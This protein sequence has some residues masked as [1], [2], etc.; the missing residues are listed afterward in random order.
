M[1]TSAW[2]GV[3]TA[4]PRSGP[5]CVRVAASSADLTRCGCTW[6]SSTS[7]LPL[8]H[9]RQLR[10]VLL[11]PDV[12]AVSPAL[13]PGDAHQAWPDEDP[14]QASVPDHLP[15][16]TQGSGVSPRRKRSAIARRHRWM[17]RPPLPGS[18]PYAARLALERGPAHEGEK[19]MQFDWVDPGSTQPAQIDGPPGQSV[20]T[21]CPCTGEWPPSAAKA[22][23]HWHPARPAPGRRWQDPLPRGRRGRHPWSDQSELSPQ[24][25]HQGRPAARFDE[26]GPQPG[27]SPLPLLVPAPEAK[28]Q[29]RLSPAPASNSERRAALAR[30]SGCALLHPH[31][32]TSHEGRRR[33]LPDG[34]RPQPIPMAP[35]HARGVML[36]SL[37][38]CEGMTSRDR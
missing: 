24:I 5:P 12:H 15:V 2:M 37:D 31:D 11:Q 29:D 38:T 22:S 19:R 34:V 13:E 9:S 4:L 32:R 18:E 8:W 26:S 33:A 17:R 20:P 7:S 16:P 36:Q 14:P 27:P 1:A 23:A 25:R 21:S 6:P 30:L 10:G 28:P 3:S 35:D